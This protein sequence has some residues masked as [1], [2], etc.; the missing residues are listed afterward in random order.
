[1]LFKTNHF[2]TFLLLLATSFTG[3]SQI[4]MIGKIIDKKTQTPL[5]F[6]DVVLSNRDIKVGT[7]TDENGR[8]AL[9]LKKGKYKLSV[10]YMGQSLYS[11]DMSIEKNVDIG[12]LE[13]FTVHNQLKEVTVLAKKKLIEQKTDRFIFHVEHS[14]KAL[15]GNA[16]DVLQAT[17]DIQVGTKKIAL[18]GK[19]ELSVLIDDQIIPLSNEDLV[20]YLESIPSENIKEIEIITAPPVKYEAAGNSGLI[21]I[22]LKKTKNNFWNAQ[23]KSLYKQGRHPS[24]GLSGNF[25][26]NKNR[27]G[28]SSSVSVRNNNGYVDGNFYTGF[29]DELWHT[30]FPLKG[31]RKGISTRLDLSYELAP[32]WSMG[33]RLLYNKDDYEIIFRPYT[34]VFDY[35]TKD[36]IRT[37]DS[38]L[39]A[40]D[41][42]PEIQSMNY[43]NAIELDTLGKKIMLD[44][45]YFK[46][47]KPDERRYEGVSVIRSPFLKQYYKGFN[48]NILHPV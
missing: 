28:F 39:N 14:P 21:N 42:D 17:P 47:K 29:P 7:M 2:L 33:W 9:A 24:G 15:A 6:V 36:T 27:F 12:L 40:R 26:Y 22:K 31:N 8:F 1:M 18:I 37:L 25:N 48:I 23:V 20:N 34:T 44:L 5:V 10:L 43:S 46:Y 13:I 38:F 41:V 30:S 16:L 3:F 19:S 4:K 32:K 35:K 45:G 11:T